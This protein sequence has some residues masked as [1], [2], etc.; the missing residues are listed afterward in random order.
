MKVRDLFVVAAILAASVVALRWSSAS[1]P[2]YEML[3]VRPWDLRGIWKDT[4]PAALEAAAFWAIG[5]AVLGGVARRFDPTL[6]VVDRILAGVIGLWAVAYVGAN[7][8]GPI[9]LFRAWT[10]WTVLILCWVWQRRRPVAAPP[11]TFSPGEQLLALAALVTVPVVFLVQM[12]CPVPPYMDILAT[13]A[14]AQRVLTFGRYLPFDSDPY[15]YWGPSLQ[16]PGTEL[17]YALVALGS[18]IRP[19]VLAVSAS[20]LPLTLAFIIAT[21]RLGRS[22]GGDV[23]GGFATLLLPATVMLHVL[24]YSHGR[25]VAFVPAVAALAFLAEPSRSP[26]RVALGA[27]ALALA[28]A[29]HAIIG[30]LAALVA[31]IIVVR[32]WWGIVVLVG[33]GLLA[34]PE[35]LI[36]LTLAVP[37]PVLPLLQLAGLTVIVWA[38][39]RLRDLG[40]EWRS[41]RIVAAVAA[42]AILVW[43]PEWSGVRIVAR[44]YPLLFAGGLL[45]FAATPFLPRRVFVVPFAFGVLTSFAVDAVSRLWWQKIPSPTIGLAVEDLYHK[46]EYWLPFMLLWPT[47]MLVRRLVDAV[48]LRIPLYATVA[49]VAFPWLCRTQVCDPNLASHSLV[50]QWA[51]SVEF[52]KSGYWASMGDRRWAQSPAQFKL[53]DILLDEVAAGRITPATHIAQ[54]EPYVILYQDTVLFTVYTGINGDTYVQDWK[55]D[56]STAAGRFY[57]IE[58]FAKRLE[59]DPPP[60]VVIH[61]RTLNARALRTVPPLPE[62]YE[63][64][65]AEDGVRLWRRRVS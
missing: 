39:P 45:G 61:E 26:V 55:L 17:L 59:T 47:A 1:I 52:S 20:I 63:E 48:G 7:V 50:Q 56:R 25:F 30:A 6:D 16:C 11:F 3:V 54:L 4:L 23:A 51:H 18:T 21:Y 43:C 42:L 44:R 40:L 35:V 53:R 27:V 14:S 37:Y 19:A 12:G 13:P 5:V 57:P 31:T 8:L 2:Y 32:E 60:Y 36:A 15:G 29:S 10:I 38:A 65:L 64:L 34:M 58:Q 41:V 22:L 46:V 24:P 49:L 62:G 28:I 33:A 9:G